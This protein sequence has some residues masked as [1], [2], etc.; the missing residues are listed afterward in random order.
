MQEKRQLLIKNRDEFN[1]LEQEKV[2]LLP[3]SHTEG[4]KVMDVY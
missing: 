2:T 4:W 1:T 3:D